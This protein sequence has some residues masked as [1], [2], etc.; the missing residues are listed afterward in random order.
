MTTTNDGMGI[1]ISRRATCV[2]CGTFVDTN[3]NGTYR[4]AVGWLPIK[5]FSGNKTG[6]NSLT[7][8]IRLDHWACAECVDRLKHGI[9]PDQQ[10][11]FPIDLD[12]G[13]IVPGQS[14]RTG[15]PND[16]A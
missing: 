1:P 2:Y 16:V 12:D 8:P 14:P 4:R 3:A 15:V 11:L 13:R 7:L 5:R 6:T 10:S 9:S